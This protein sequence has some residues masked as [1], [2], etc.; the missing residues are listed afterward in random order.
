M[1]ENELM[2]FMYLLFGIGIVA[3]VY[4]PKIF[5]AVLPIIALVGAFYLVWGISSHMLSGIFGVANKRKDDWWNGIAILT[6]IILIYGQGTIAVKS[7][8]FFVLLIWNV[9]FGTMTLAL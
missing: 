9:I 3:L 5:N 4:F 2:E 6:V 1:N 8:M 7:V